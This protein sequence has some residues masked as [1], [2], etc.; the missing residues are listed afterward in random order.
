[1]SFEPSQALLDQLAEEGAIPLNGRALDAAIDK[2]VDEKIDERTIGR[3]KTLCLRYSLDSWY[4]EDKVVEQVLKEVKLPENHDLSKVRDFIIQKADDCREW[5]CDDQFEQFKEDLIQQYQE[6]GKAF[7]LNSK[8]REELETS[9]WKFGKKILEI[10]DFLMGTRIEFDDEPMHDADGYYSY[11]CIPFDRDETINDV[12]NTLNYWEGE[13]D[14]EYFSEALSQYIET[15]VRERVTLMLLQAYQ[16]LGPDQDNFTYITASNIA[17]RIDESEDYR[18]EWLE[19]CTP[20][21]EE[22]EALS[23]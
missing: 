3:T 10:D 12:A 22:E 6:Y 17:F 9:E 18:D 13:I 1:M 23:A 5:N 14:R 19:A 21:C 7:P 4:D 15:I 8:Q 2:F 16:E 11:L 20:E